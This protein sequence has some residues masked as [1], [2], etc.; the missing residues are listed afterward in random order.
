MLPSTPAWP[1]IFSAR[2]N[3]EIQHNMTEKLIFATRPS[4]LARWQTNYIIQQ[5]QI[6]W[7]TL[8]CESLVITTKG[9]RIIDRPLPEIGGKGLFTYELESALRSGRVHAAV[10]SLKDLPVD[11]SPDLTIGLIPEREDLRDVL[12]CPDGHTIETLPHGAI[13]GTS[14]FRRQA[15]ILIQRPDLRVKPI[16]G[17]VETR[18][19]KAKTADYDAIVMAAAGVK[20]LGLA[21]EI[22][23]YFSFDVMLPAPGQGALGVQ[24]R[25]DDAATLRLLAVLEDESAR[26]TTIAE[27][28]F[29]A[30]LGGGCSI[31]V[32]ARATLNGDQI[33]LY[34]LVA[35]TDGNHVIRVQ[36]RGSD[37]HALGAVLAEQALEQGASQILGFQA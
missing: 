35:S 2:I 30:G 26:D 1:A 25:I 24:C 29:L 36:A 4:T 8:I 32:A 11:D 9:D 16:R 31:P 28:S 3:Q 14:S 23:E 6:A 20:R 21:G 13:V 34:G 19:A 33:S 7:P 5:L 18:I 12:I 22:S 17:N 37:A 10:H 27:R 15:Q